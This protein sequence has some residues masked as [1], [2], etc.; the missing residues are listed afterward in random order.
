MPS[1]EIITIGTELLLGDIVD[2]NSR[3]LARC[4]RDVGIDL[5]RKTTVGDNISRIAQV[6]QE[7]LT[8]CDI[9]ITS[10]GLGPTVDDPTRQAVSKAIGVELEFH[11]D[12]WQQIKKRF[13]RMGRI[14]TENNRRQAFI[15]SGAIAFENAVG[16]APIFILEHNSHLI[17]SLPGVP[18]E[19]EYLTVQIVLP[20]LCQYYDL[21]GIIKSRVL[22]TVGVGES[23][24]DDLIGDLEEL[25]NPTVGLAAHSGQVDVRITAK[26]DT[27]AGSE[28]LIRP[29]EDTIRARLGDWIFGVDQETLEEVALRS[30]TAQQWSLIVIEAGLGGILTRKLAALHGPFIGGQVLTDAPT[31]EEL[32][33]LTDSY[34]LAQKADVGLGVS[35]VQTTQSY[36]VN[37]VLLTPP[38]THKMKRSYSGVPEYAIMWAFNQSLNLIRRI[39]NES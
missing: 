26:A 23:Q 7:S 10:G 14:P 13:Q 25:S 8:R 22:H 28:E 9:I 37:F 19:L 3:Y 11:P 18:R 12:L 1:A 36:D 34:R 38:K 32:E 17:I 39:P 5:Y 16:T 27:E 29:L 30:I 20:Y 4:L 24:I 15:P 6:I 2:T 31:A 35:L 33:K 21:H